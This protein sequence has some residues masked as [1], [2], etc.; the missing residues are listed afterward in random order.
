M[1]KIKVQD[2]EKTMTSYNENYKS[3][4]N[5]A[6]S[7]VYE[8]NGNMKWKIFILFIL[9][10]IPFHDIHSQSASSTTNN[11]TTLKNKANKGDPEALFTLAN[12]YVDG[13]NGFPR[14]HSKAAML[15]KKAALK[16]HSLSAL[17]Y[18]TYCRNFSHDYRDGV[19]FLTIAAENG[20]PEAE[21][22]LG[23]AYWE[24]HLL[25]KDL[26]K[27]EFWIQKS[28][29]DGYPNGK[30]WMPEIKAEIALAQRKTTSLKKTETGKKAKTFAP[31]D[32]DK[33]IFETST[34]NNHTFAIILSNEIYES[35][36]HVPY[37]HHDGE[38]LH[39][40]FIKTLGIPTENIHFVKDATR[41]DI[42]F[43]VNWAKKMMEAHQGDAKLIFYYA[44]HGI[45][46]E[47]SKDGYLLPSDGI[48]SDVSTAYSLKDLYQQ[49]NKL[50]SKAT[51]VLL[52]ACFSGATRE[53]SMIEEARSVAIKVKESEPIG[54]MVVI[55]AAT[56]EQTAAPYDEMHHGIFTYFLLK[57]IKETKG[58]VTIGVLSDYVIAQVKRNS[59]IENGKLQTP[60]VNASNTVRDWRN[61]NLK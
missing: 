3:L 2:A 60:T 49:L 25:A 23:M 56:G 53:G 48:S 42:R 55:S 12:Y 36:Q 33:D 19:K 27:A 38:T 46:D 50:P 13:K 6:C 52:D 34:I 17:S 47:S 21:Y 15:Y 43:H 29:E 37:A 57:I 41:N 1:G 59:L 24:N 35:V 40:Y 16:G 5:I 7:Q 54:S 51:I 10:G 18:F 9:I 26:Q 14:S 58:E 32:V 11:I 20:L 31:S 39:L 30:K 4:T 8:V 45:P 61:W 44:G 28:I 22:V